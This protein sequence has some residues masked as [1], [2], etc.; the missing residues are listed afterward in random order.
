MTNT[1]TSHA[2]NRDNGHQYFARRELIPGFP[3]REFE[4]G[5]NHTEYWNDADI[6]MIDGKLFRCTNQS[7]LILLRSLPLEL[8]EH[9]FHQIIDQHVPDLERI[10]YALRTTNS[11]LPSHWDRDRLKTEAYKKMLPRKGAGM[12][13]KGLNIGDL[14]KLG[15]L[16]RIPSK[17]MSTWES[18][19]LK[20]A[21]NLSKSIENDYIV[22]RLY[23]EFLEFARASAHAE[24][25]TLTYEDI[26][27]TCV[28]RWKSSDKNS[29][30]LRNFLTWFWREF[31]LDFTCEYGTGNKW[32]QANSQQFSLVQNISI[33]SEKVLRER[34]MPATLSQGKTYDLPDD[35]GVAGLFDTDE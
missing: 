21:I 19:S 28:P 31:E 33:D 32:L 9:V 14:W 34:L 8:Q 29:S 20:E 5:I 23:G 3:F 4:S 22:V 12:N 15:S 13:F 11:V 35:L 24:G 2:S 17:T 1:Q 30:L 18:D 27:G 6:R 10:L 25:F 26:N 7:T 16:V